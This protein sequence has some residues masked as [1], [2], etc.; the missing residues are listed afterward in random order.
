M[1]QSST[2]PLP[3]LARPAPRI[4]ALDLL[5]GIAILGIFLMNT[6]TM[7]YPQY[8][9]SN[10]AVYS[11]DWKLDAGFPR[12]NGT[13]DF[14]LQALT[15][16]NFWTYAIIHLL[17]D[18]KFIT[19]FSILF[20]AGIVL[21]ADRSR[22]KGHNPWVVHYLRMTILLLFGLC[23]TFGFWFGDILTDYAMLG[24]LL[25]PLRLLPAGQLMFLGMALVS[26]STLYDYAKMHDWIPWL[27]SHLDQWET[28]VRSLAPVHNYYDSNNDMELH[29]YRSG[30]WTQIIEHRFVTSLLGHTKE[31]VEW[32]FFRCGGCLLIGMALQKRRFF[33][34][35]WPRGAYATI[36]LI[37][38]PVGW[39]IISLGIQ[40]NQYH[41]WTDGNGD[42]FDLW[43][44]GMAFN[45]WGS[46]LCA[47]GYISFGVL[48]A[49]WAADPV[50]KGWY[51]EFARLGY[52]PISAIGAT[53][54]VAPMHQIFR[55]CLI[56]I[57]SVGRMALTCYLTETL[58]GTTL[59]YGHGFGKFG[60]FTRPELVYMV[61]L[62]TWVFIMLFAT[63]WLSIFRQGPLEWF[64]HSI[65]YWDWKNPLKTAAG[66]DASLSPSVAGS[67]GDA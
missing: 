31:F 17:A 43:H 63:V 35:I 28:Y 13:Y 54:A 62:P 65:V 56:P 10:P 9:Y 39:I 18:M 33:Q 64:W 29:I 48:L 1:S 45:Y 5:R 6:W 19:T 25:A 60:K 58:I 41:G 15:G 3:E 21:Q 42:L 27:T 34:G 12:N 37:C 66:P 30:W 67:A 32:T 51:A 26:G 14:G 7:S 53:F 46:L 2:P 50:K 36:A 16:A 40:F 20:G 24:L 61:V 57:R 22:K 23:H 49:L 52:T 47:F 11:P 44:M 38:A 59:F 8:A 4:D 55:M